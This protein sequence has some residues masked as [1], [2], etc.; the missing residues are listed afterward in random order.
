[1]KGSGVISTGTASSPRR[2]TMTPRKS[3][4]PSGCICGFEDCKIPHGFCHCGCGK[5]TNIIPVTNTK[6]GW[7]KG[8]PQKFIVGHGCSKKYKEIIPRDICICGNHKCGVAYGLCHCGCGKTT[9][10]AKY[11]NREWCHIKGHPVMYVIGH[12]NVQVRKDVSNISR[13]KIDGVYCR[14]IS[15]NKGM[16]TIID[17]SDYED[18]SQWTW[19]AWWNSHTRSYYA[20][21]DTSLRDGGKHIYMHRY[22]LRLTEKD[23]TEADHI[24]PPATLD[25]RRKN[26]RF[27]NSSQQSCNTCL[28]TD[29]TSGFKGVSYQKKGNKWKAQINIKGKVT[30][31]GLCDTAERAYFDLY[32]P[33]ALKYYGEFA[34]LS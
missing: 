4:S 34:R 2:A 11:N 13:F 32:V 9:P 30:C 31:L 23:V 24:Y 28:R 7:Y 19:T 8:F 21:R 10:I 12:Q 20:V 3:I 33:A 17:E 25:N 22:I 26:L 1:M 16:Y 5:T 18:V 29:N 15:L 27:A 14:L 6:R